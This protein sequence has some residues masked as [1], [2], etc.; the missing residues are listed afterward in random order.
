MR[1]SNKQPRHLDWRPWQDKSI[2]LHCSN[3]TSQIE[4]DA[5]TKT[6]GKVLTNHYK[7]VLEFNAKYE[8]QKRDRFSNLLIWKKTETFSTLGI[9]AQ[10]CSSMLLGILIQKLRNSAAQYQCIIL[11]HKVLAFF[12]NLL[13]VFLTSIFQLN[14]LWHPAILIYIFMLTNVL[15]LHSRCFWVPILTCFLGRDV[16]VDSKL[17][18]L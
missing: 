7:C 8:Y 9:K 18:L 1:R 4:R 3:C 10:L 2:F 11:K 13:Y 5:Q 16:A 12:P 6:K 15:K 17:L 14:S